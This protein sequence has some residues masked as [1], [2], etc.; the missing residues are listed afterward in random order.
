MAVL[1]KIVHL[2]ILVSIS[3]KWFDISTDKGIVAFTVVPL[4]IIKAESGGKILPSLCFFLPLRA[5][6]IK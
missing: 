1:G 2:L 6:N 4:D 5:Q 3:V